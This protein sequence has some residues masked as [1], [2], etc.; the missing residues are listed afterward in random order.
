M[1]PK[2]SAALSQVLIFGAGLAAMAYNIYQQKKNPD[3]EALKVQAHY[4]YLSL[5]ALLSGT[6]AGVYLG[7]LLP[8]ILQMLL[9]FFICTFGSY[10]ILTRAVRTF[11]AE[12]EAMARGRD[13][14]AK[15]TSTTPAAQALGNGGKGPVPLEET[16]VEVT[17]TAETR[18]AEGMRTAKNLSKFVL[19]F[20]F[21]TFFLLFIK[22]GKGMKSIFGVKPCGAAF[23]VLVLAQ[24]VGQLALSLYYSPKEWVFILKSWGIGIATT[25]SGAS[26][27]VLQNPLMMAYGLS[28]L[29]STPVSVIT[30]FVTAS[31]SALDFLFGGVVPFGYVFASGITFAGSITGMIGIAAVIKKTGRPSLLIF[32]LGVMAGLGGLTVLMSGISGAF[33]SIKN[34]DNPLAFEITC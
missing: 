14:L 22:G 28:P 3:Y 15:P 29:H 6:L 8:N 11:K 25:M 2:L 33:A 19:A 26:P 1:S 24:I 27:G 17:G 20:L 9:L 23:W 18:E 21:G 31:V 5:P 32:V 16:T 12:S 13:T 10:T 7:K 34:G 4:V 30:T